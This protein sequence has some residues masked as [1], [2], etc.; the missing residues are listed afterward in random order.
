MSQKFL[1]KH[2]PIGSIVFIETYGTELFQVIKHLP[3]NR[4]LVRQKNT[5]ITYEVHCNHCTFVAIQKLSIYDCPHELAK[6]F[7]EVKTIKDLNRFFVSFS[8]ECMSEE[9]I[10]RAMKLL[11]PEKRKYL[12]TLCQMHKMAS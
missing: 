3:K 1:E 8:Q 2:Y 4:L 6:Y 7:L 11:P 12:V 10:K 5:L 9:H